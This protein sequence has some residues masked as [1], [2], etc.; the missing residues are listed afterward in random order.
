MLGRPVQTALSRGVPALCDSWGSGPGPWTAAEA[1]LP[2][3]HLL[4][5]EAAA[6]TFLDT[7]PHP[8]GNSIWHKQGRHFL[9]IYIRALI[10]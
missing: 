10:C 3:P 8:P 2:P 4:G 9:E 5:A 1:R 6:F 7:C